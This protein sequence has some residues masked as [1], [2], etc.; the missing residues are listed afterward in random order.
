MISRLI[1]KIKNKY[2]Y[3][4]ILVI[5]ISFF[6]G[7]GLVHNQGSKKAALVL[8]DTKIILNSKLKNERYIS[9]EELILNFSN[10]VYYD[11]ISRKLII[12]SN[13]D[14]LKIKAQDKYAFSEGNQVWYDIYAISEYFGY[15]AIYDVRSNSIY[16]YNEEELP[17]VVSNSRTFV[18]TN[19]AE[20]IGVLDYNTRVKIL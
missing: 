2:W 12:T 6:V 10:N 17:A 20:I 15:K 7:I 11:R 1:E 8:G 13:N 19:E 3:I 9:L 16:I 5:Y 14:I 4:I 18:Y